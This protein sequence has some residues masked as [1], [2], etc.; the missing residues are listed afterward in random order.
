MTSHQLL[1]VAMLYSMRCASHYYCNIQ[2]CTCIKNI[3]STNRP[4]LRTP[5]LAI[6]MH[7]NP[8]PNLPPTWLFLL[9]WTWHWAFQCW[10]HIQ[11]SSELGGLVGPSSQ[12]HSHWGQCHSPSHQQRQTQRWTYR[13]IQKSTAISNYIAVHSM[14]TCVHG[15]LGA[16]RRC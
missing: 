3:H 9:Y 10:M 15:L 1:H 14:Y 13:H 7:L 16:W 12:W 8:V 11:L 6:A 4:G 2:A 5:A